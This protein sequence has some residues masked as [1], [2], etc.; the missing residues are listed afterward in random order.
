MKALS[1]TVHPNITNNDYYY[2][3]LLRSI[4]IQ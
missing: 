3:L 4:E 2:V 1:P